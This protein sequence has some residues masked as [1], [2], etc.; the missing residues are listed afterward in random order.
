MAPVAAPET[1]ADWPF[2]VRPLTRALGAEILGIDLDRAAS[3]EIFPS[4]LGV[5]ISRAGVRIIFRYALP[6]YPASTSGLMTW[7]GLPA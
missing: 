6:P 4:C 3:P 2:E 5:A 1:E 7:I